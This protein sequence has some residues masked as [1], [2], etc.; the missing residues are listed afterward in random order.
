VK[1]A[2]LFEA[3]QVALS[4]LIVLLGAGMVK[5]L[6]GTFHRRHTFRQAFTLVAYG[7]SPFFVMRMLDAAPISPW[8]AWAIGFFLSASALYQGV[9]VVMQPDPPQAFGLYLISVLLLGVTTG[10]ARI[11]TAWYLQG[12]FG[13]LSAWMPSSFVS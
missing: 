4:L 7:L 6:G 10:L 3:A 5:S 8:I 12:K 11:V 1:D 9:P 13:S 2:L